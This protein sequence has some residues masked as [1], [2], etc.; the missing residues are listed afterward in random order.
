MR[1]LVITQPGY[2]GLETVPFI[3]QTR[4]HDAYLPLHVGSVEYIRAVWE[5]FGVIEPAPLGYPIELNPYYN[6]NISI[7]RR[8][9][10]RD[11][12]TQPK[13]VKPL[14]PKV[15]EPEIVKQEVYNPY[16]S[17]GKTARDWIEQEVVEFD[18]EYRVYCV[19]NVI[20]GYGRYDPNE[21][22]DLKAVEVF[23][24][25]ENVIKDWK[26]NKPIAYAIDV[27]V[28]KGRGL[29]IVELTDA[30][31]IGLY[32]P[33]PL[34]AYAEMLRLRWDQIVKN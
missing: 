30:W 29:S 23:A 33:C 18:Q 20:V 19:K 14:F 34:S 7:I 5:K 12:T 11:Y 24:F 32:K 4:P 3:G 26:T 15:F 22:E 1:D 10:K 25:V 6:R 2:S 8:Y 16:Q 21:S 9:G 13:F 31:A 27:G 17:N 28:I